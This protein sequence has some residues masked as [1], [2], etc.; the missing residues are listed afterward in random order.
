[1]VKRF[2]TLVQFDGIISPMDR[3]MHQKTYGMKIQFNNKAEGRVAWQDGDRIKIDMIRF[4]MGDIRT[5]VHG[6]NETVRERLVQ[7]LMFTNTARLPALDLR[8]IYEQRGRDQRGLQFFGRRPESV[9]GRGGALVV[10]T[11]VPR[12]SD[13]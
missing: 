2:M 10:E 4:T 13:R 8:Q 1:M 6:L 5:V 7:D 11:H 12:E 3:I 9:R